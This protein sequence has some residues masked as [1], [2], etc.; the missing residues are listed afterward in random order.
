MSQEAKTLSA[1]L[2]DKQFHI[3]LQEAPD[4]LFRTH[5]DIWHF[6]KNYVFDNNVLP[7]TS[8]VEESFPDFVFYDDVGTTRFHL[9]EL[10][11]EY[12]DDALR[13]TLKNTIKKVQDGKLEDALDTIVLETSNIRRVTSTVAD[14]DALDVEAAVAHIEKLRQ[15]NES[16]S[17]GVRTGLPGFDNYL[18]GGIL[19]GQLGILLAYP[20]IG[21][22]WMALYFALQAWKNGKRP[23][24]VSLEMPETEV[25]NRAYTILGNGKFSNRQINEGLVNVDELRDWG[26]TMFTDRPP[27]IIVS[28]DGGAVSPTVLRGKIHQYHPDIIIVDYIQLMVPDGKYDNEITKIKNLSTQLKQLALS[29]HVPVVAIASA[30]PKPDESGFVDM[31]QPP[32]LN[33]TAWST[34]IQYDAD[35]LLALGREK[36]SSIINAVFRK[37]RNGFLG[38]FMVD[39]NFDRGIFRYKDFE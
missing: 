16:G 30:T 9:S 31:Q 22:S 35:W 3:L 27:I 25:R 14:V 39:A 33:Q 36:N 1:V 34:Q 29:E 28:S 32:Q 8:L 7:P 2:K 6:I 12:L 13:V 24:I 10:K 5:L 20:G 11:R 4:E 23:L 38:E 19:P 15:L 17:Y 37:N 18:P 26:R 21:K